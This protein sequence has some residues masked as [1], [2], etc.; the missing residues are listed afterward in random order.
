MSRLMQRLGWRE[1]RDEEMG[2]DTL[3]KGIEHAAEQPAEQSAEPINA[4]AGDL[5]EAQLMRLRK[6]EL[7]NMLT[8]ADLAQAVL[9][10]Q[11]AETVTEE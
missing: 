10:K 1:Q 4:P 7:A 5:T 2:V 11:A 3:N 8:K 6:D 9:D